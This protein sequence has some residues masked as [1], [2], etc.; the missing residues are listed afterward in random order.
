MVK[1]PFTLKIALRFNQNKKKTNLV[2]LISIIS[3]FGIVLGVSVL[4]I[5]LSAMN[6]FEFELKKRIL[7]IVLHGQISAINQPYLNWRVDLDKVRQTPGV[8]GVSPYIN[9]TG[10]LEKDSKLKAIK[11]IGVDLLSEKLVSSLPNFILNNAWQ[12]FK[13]NNNEIILGQ[14]IAE[15]LKVLPGDHLTIMIPN[16]DGKMYI[17]QPNKINANVIGIFKLNSILDHQLAIVPLQDAQKYLAYG[18]GITGFQISV[19][20]I[21]SANKIV[22]NA[23][24]NTGHYVTIKSWITDYGYI[25]NDIQIVRSII[26][27]SMILVISVACFNII[28]TLVIAV[29]DKS[30]DIAILRTLGGKDSFIRAIFLWYGLITGIIGCFIG[31]LLGI[32]ISLNLTTIIKYIENI[33]NHP[34]LFGDIYFI[35]FLPSKIHNM[36]IFYITLTTLIL[37]LL[38]SWYPAKRAT[39]IDPVRILSRK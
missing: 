35:D 16:H 17:Q 36:D 34:I 33:I 22:Y 14:G 39:K 19:S 25:Y 18:D 24:I 21:F 8:L 32:F 2:S 30:I 5:G 3:I 38:A 10:L 11:I 6:G 28:S 23:G 37:S 1:L 9:F 29:K 7:S 4:I 31:V 26:Y 12:K 27:L 20:D 15:T 13:P